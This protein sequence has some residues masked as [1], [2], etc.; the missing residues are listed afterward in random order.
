MIKMKM[1]SGNTVVDPT[2]QAIRYALFDDPAAWSQ[3]PDV[4][5]NFT[6]IDKKSSLLIAYAPG[7]GYYV[8][9]DAGGLWVLVHHPTS[10]AKDVV[11]IDQDYQV[12][13]GLLCDKDLTWAAVEWFINSGQ[14]CPSLNWVSDHDLPEGVVF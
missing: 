5:L 11:E 1:S 6:A 13:A 3:A 2:A 7:Q 12:S 8:Q 4:L 10:I 9:Y 14:M